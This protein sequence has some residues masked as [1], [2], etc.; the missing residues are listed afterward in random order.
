MRVFLIFWDEYS[1]DQFASAIR[2]REALT[3]LVTTAFQ[4]TDLVALMDQLT[5]TDA[6]RFTRDFNDLSLDVKKLRGR[7]GVYIPTRSAVE[8]A[9]LMRRR[10]YPAAAGGGDAVGAEVGGGLPRDAARGPEDA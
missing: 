3:E 8:E 6:I 5:P 7:L 4:P 2:A 9:Q 1:I 10:R